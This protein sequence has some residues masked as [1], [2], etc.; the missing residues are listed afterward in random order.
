[1]KRKLEKSVSE[2]KKN[3]L[4]CLQFSSEIKIEPK[5]KTESILFEKKLLTSKLKF[6]KIWRFEKEEIF[7]KK[8]RFFDFQKE[9]YICSI[10][11]TIF[12]KKKV[13]KEKQILKIKLKFTE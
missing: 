13:Q 7:F 8:Q 1:M 3:L 10:F 9:I 5:E 6:Y 12:M 4:E 11:S 2:G